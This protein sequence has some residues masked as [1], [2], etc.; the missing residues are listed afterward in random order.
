MSTTASPQWTKPFYG[1][2]HLVAHEM[3][4]TVEDRGTFSTGFIFSWASY[5]FVERDLAWRGNDHQEQARQYMTA[6]QNTYLGKE[7]SMPIPHATD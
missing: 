3:Q 6:R 4:F 1:V 2:S 7:P 5:Q